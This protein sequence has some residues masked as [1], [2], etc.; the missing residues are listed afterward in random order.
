MCGIAGIYNF[1]KK[2]INYNE[3]SIMADSVAHRGPDDSGIVMLDE[4]PRL[5]SFNSG[6]NLLLEGN[7]HAGF[8]HRR[9]SI[10]DLSVRGRQPMSNDTGELWITYNGE[11]FNYLEIRRELEESGRQFHSSTDTEVLL[12]AYDTWGTACM[13]KF[14]GMWAFAIWDT[15]HRRL[16]ISRDRF[17]IKPLYYAFKQGKFAFA[18]EPKALLRLPWISNEPDE[19]AIADYL[20][21]SRVDCFEWTFFKNIIRLEPGCCFEISFQTDTLPEPRRWWNIN[22]TLY[23]PDQSEKNVEQQFLELFTSSVELRLRSDVPIGTNLSGGIDSSAVVCIARPWL[24]KNNQ[25]TYSAVYGPSFEEDE[26][27]Y[28]DEIIRFVEVENYRVTPTA[29]ELIND[30]N[31]LV[32]T[33]DEPFG[34]TSQYAQFKVFQLAG[35][36]GTKVILNG[37]GADEELAGYHYLLPVYCAGLI[38]DGKFAEAFREFIASRKVTEASFIKT[39]FST[40]AGFLSHRS[41]I[42]YANLYDYGRSV[43]WVRKDIREYAQ[44]IQVQQV[45]KHDW[46]NG[47][48]HELFSFSSLPALLRYEDRNSM[49]FSIESRLPFIDHRLV[50]FIFSLPSN[51]KIHKG[52]T[53]YI[54]RKALK[55]KIPES[56]RTRNN[57]IGFSTPESS[58]FR[59]DMLSYIRDVLDS[60][61]TKKRGLY[62]IPNLLNLINANA[63]GKVNAGR[64]IWRALNLELWFRRFID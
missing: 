13:E 58:W 43:N 16:F 45:R 49:A 29:E 5:C 18:S 41:M 64:A 34:S 12:I 2:P 15:R 51:Q 37:Q 31:R 35:R 27:L 42:R 53:K 57:K 62:D 20:I 46:L 17:G 24:D 8:A 28:I 54:M 39:F 50:S 9:L 6:D 1:D 23:E 22:E 44:T 55:G 48:L 4:N 36:Y 40:L 3:L 60:P 38:R 26:T 61:V 14:N 52:M 56:I 47:R 19:R 59:K 33:Q 21:H 30:I 63:S 7:F 10:I 25:K 32:Y 11:I